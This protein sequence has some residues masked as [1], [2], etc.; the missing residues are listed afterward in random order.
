MAP[1]DLA[2][3]SS[4]LALRLLITLARWKALRLTLMGLCVV[5]VGAAVSTGI[6]WAADPNGAETLEEN[7]NAAVNFAWTLMA[8]FLVF[9]MQAGFALLEAGSVRAKSTV[10]VLTKN[11][12]DFLM[13]GMAFWAFGFAIMFGGSELAPGLADGN[14]FFGASGFFLA[15]DAYD[16]STFELWFF[17]MVFAAT[18]ATIVSG[19]MAERT[20]VNAYMAY[21][22]LISA[23][24][25][26]VFG[27][28]AWGGGWLATMATPFRDFAGSGVVHTVGG[29]AALVGGV[30]VGPRLGKYGPDGKPRSIPGHS[31]TLVVLG[32]LILFLGWFGFNPGSTLAATDLR[33]S[34]IAVNTFLAGVAGGLSAYYIR[35]VETGKVDIG[36]TCSGIIGGLVAI[37][38]PCAFV[39]SWA[40]VVIGGV[41]GPIVVYG[42]RFLESVVK[43]DDP[44]W[45]VPCHMFSGLWGL[46]AVGVFA[47]GTYLEVSGLIDGSADQLLSQLIGMAAVVVWTSITS[48]L[49]FAG[50]KLTMGLRVP[51]ED[52]VAGVDVSEHTQV[53]YPPDELSPAAASG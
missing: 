8:A 26:P 3:A 17:Q 43:V 53:A 28:W 15:G 9:F 32:M 21:S 12:V 13:C 19:T 52:E 35:F 14:D 49:V 2:T 20:K 27:H 5:L 25:Y 23:I 50:I 7:P 39:E 37:T 4:P 45:A 33:I 38:A 1:R 51:H 47:D 22:F 46:L 40:A 18:A 24:I 31:V 29:T 36:A 11:I 44:V 42:A 48:L 34:V 16:V 10:N 30:M 41:A 6:A